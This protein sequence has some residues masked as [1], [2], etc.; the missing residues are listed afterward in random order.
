MYIEIN[1]LRYCGQWFC[2]SVGRAVASDTRDPWFESSNRQIL[3]TIKRIKS[4]LKGRKK[5]PVIVHLKNY[6]A[7]S[8]TCKVRLGLN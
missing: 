8:Y 5:M 7:L 4:V 6:D 2:G 3:F 1:Y